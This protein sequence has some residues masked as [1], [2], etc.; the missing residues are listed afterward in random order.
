MYCLE[1][2]TRF[3]EVQLNN[4][5]KELIRNKNNSSFETYND[6]MGMA[7][8]VY[9]PILCKSLFLTSYSMLEKSLNEICVTL[10]QHKSFDVSYKDIKG[11]G[12]E[13]AVLYLTKVISLKKLKNC[14]SWNELKHWNTARNC[15]L[16]NGGEVNEEELNKI[17]LTQ[18]KVE[19]VY[20]KLT[21]IMSY[22][23]C[24]RFLKTIELFVENIY[25]ALP[26]NL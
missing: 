21:L 24:R 17:E 11:Q 26:K 13:R 1:N 2:A 7:I 10:Q 14:V 3:L 18:L 6:N 8:T 20:D 12:I 4:H 16:H 5:F 25:S 22:E 19:E 9:E 23:S 15:F